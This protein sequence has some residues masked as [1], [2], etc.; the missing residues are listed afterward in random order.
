D[1]PGQ[2]RRVHCRP[3]RTALVLLC[4]A[5]ASPQPRPEASPAPA[6]PAP[7]APAEKT[8]SGHGAA[9]V[10]K[11]ALEKYAPR[12]IPD[13][14]ARDIQSM[15][16]VRA[17]GPGVPAP[18]GSALYFNWRVT[19]VLQMWRL[20][21]PQRFPVQ[22]TGG[23]DQTLIAAVTPDGSALVVQRD[24][25]GGENPGLDLQHP[26]GGPLQPIQHKP[27]VQTEFQFV[28]DDSR[29]VYFR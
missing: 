25:K 20:D 18:D 21:G 24:R 19:G 11:E 28:T 3:M 22:L 15:L 1:G 13:D 16:D 27:G 6:A 26:K 9:S 5:C 2:W 23:Q 14:L 17:P 7:A 10:P 8:Y 4:A 12:P 29:F